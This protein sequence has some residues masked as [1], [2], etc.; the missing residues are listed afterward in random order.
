MNANGSI[1]LSV[2]TLLGSLWFFGAIV[3]IIDGEILFLFNS[4]DAFFLYI[5]LHFLLSGAALKISCAGSVAS[6]AGIADLAMTVLVRFPDQFYVIR[7]L[8]TENFFQRSDFPLK[9]TSSFFEVY[10]LIARICFTAS[11]AGKKQTRCSG[12]LSSFSLQKPLKK[13]YTST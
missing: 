7:E 8:I 9:A 13:I 2:G 5:P 1:F 4:K 11:T 3:F 10:S 6:Q 12:N